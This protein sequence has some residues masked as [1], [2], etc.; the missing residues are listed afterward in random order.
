[1]SDSRNK[2]KR[3]IFAGESLPMTDMKGIKEDS[4]RMTEWLKKRG[5]KRSF[6]GRDMSVSKPKA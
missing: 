4:K 6:N 2:P 1:M 5:L 3:R